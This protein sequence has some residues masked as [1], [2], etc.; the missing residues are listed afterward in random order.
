MSGAD[1]MREADAR[2]LV[3]RLLASAYNEAGRA[4]WWTRW[5]S[6]LGGRTPEEAWFTDRQAVIELARSIIA[7]PAT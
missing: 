5:R 2:A 6:L 4:R 7:S 1:A 3:E